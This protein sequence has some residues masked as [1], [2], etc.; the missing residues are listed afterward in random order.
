[1]RLLTVDLVEEGRE[2][3]NVRLGEIG[4][5]LSERVPLIVDLRMKGSRHD[6]TLLLRAWAT[7]EKSKRP[8]SL[9]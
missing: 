4:V 9:F 1:M 5:R 6:L 3:L 7:C 2:W 8:T